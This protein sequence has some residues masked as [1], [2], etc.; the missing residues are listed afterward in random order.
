MAFL[1]CLG[2]QPKMLLVLVP[3]LSRI[4]MATTAFIA[5]LQLL[6]PPGQMKPAN[7]TVVVNVA[8]RTI[9][10]VATAI[11]TAIA[12]ATVRAH[13][14]VLTMTLCGIQMVS[15][16]IIGSVSDPTLGTEHRLS[17]PL[18]CIFR[19]LCYNIQPEWWE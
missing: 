12:T 18:P 2:S 1:T 3:L 14:V 19:A 8:K 7:I 6:V 9:A 13:G 11:A 4:A 16:Q 17:F 15:T 5:A 10:A